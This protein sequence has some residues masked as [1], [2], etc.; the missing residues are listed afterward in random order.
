[1][2][3]HWGR[4]KISRS[5]WLNKSRSNLQ[6]IHGICHK[7][8][9]LMRHRFTCSHC[10]RRRFMCSRCKR[11]LLCSQMNFIWCRSCCRKKKNLSRRRRTILKTVMN[12]ISTK[13]PCLQRNWTGI[14]SIIRNWKSSCARKKTKCVRLRKKPL[15]SWIKVSRRR[16]PGTRSNSKWWRRTWDSLQSW[17][18]WRRFWRIHLPSWPL[19]AT[20]LRKKRCSSLAQFNTISAQL[21]NSFWPKTR[22]NLYPMP[23]CKCPR[24]SHNRWWDSRKSANLNRCRFKLTQ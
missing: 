14:S 19:Q 17:N 22:S 8:L 16:K 18:T 6:E 9:M 13:V 7:V 21:S 15:R 5:L 2:I 4:I 23:S 1:M 12:L 10:K 20:F 3:R 11:S 24:C